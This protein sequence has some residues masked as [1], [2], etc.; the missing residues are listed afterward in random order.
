MKLNLGCG[1]HYAP[2]WTNVDVADND[3]VRP[4]V[5]ADLTHALP[6]DDGSAERIYLGHVLEHLAENDLPSLLAECRRVLADGGEMVVVG[7]DC[8][9]ADK[10]LADGTIDAVEHSLVVSGAGRWASDVHLWRCTEAVV[11]EHLVGAG[12]RT[13]SVG[14]VGL[15]MN[16]W[17]VTS[18]VGWQFGLKAWPS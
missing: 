16:L 1:N 10:L 11:R 4:D 12:W 14:M 3:E 2:G 6:F 8:D 13:A 15:V 17:P 5:L 18:Q 7:P 9:R